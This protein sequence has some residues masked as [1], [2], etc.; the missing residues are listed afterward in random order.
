VNIDMGSF[1]E[2]VSPAT[3]QKLRTTA[4]FAGGGASVWEKLTRPQSSPEVKDNTVFVG[5]FSMMAFLF[6]GRSVELLVNQ[7]SLADLDK[8]KISATLLCNVG[9]R[10]PAAFGYGP[11]T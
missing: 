7:Y 10:F 11:L 9:I 8:V 1:G 5:C 4:A 2:L 3:R 6:W